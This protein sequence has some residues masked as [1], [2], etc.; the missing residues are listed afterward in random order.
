MYSRRGPWEWDSTESHY[1]G[2]NK[3]LVEG[4]GEREMSHLIPGVWVSRGPDHVLS[5]SSKSS[6]TSGKQKI[7]KYQ[8]PYWHLQPLAMVELEI[9][10]V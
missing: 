4:G 10:L 8:T 3:V 7:R 6:L 9:S 5:M 2:V 1:P